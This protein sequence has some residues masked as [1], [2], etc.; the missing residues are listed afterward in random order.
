MNSS[1]LR[2]KFLD[3]FKTNNHAII[4]SASLIPDND[5]SVLF[6]TAGMHPLVPYIMGEKHAEGKRL[7][8]VQKC[9]RTGDIDEVGDKTHHT[10]FEMLGN[11]SL[12]DYWKSEA[13][14]L[15]WNFLINELQLDKNKIAISIF[16]GNS[17]VPDYDSE[18]EKIWLDIG[19]PTE[20]I[21]KVSDN[22]WGPA[23]KTGPC[24]PDTEIFYW[25][26]DG[27]A[28]INFDEK[29]KNWVEIWNN[30]F[31][32]YNKNAQGNFEPLQQRTI[33]TGMGLERTVAAINDLDDNYKTDLFWSTIQN[34]EKI[35]GK[36]YMDHEKEFRVIVD[37]VRSAA[38]ILGDE[39]SVTPSNT[40]AGYVLR[41]LIRRAI[42]FGRKLGIQE[43]FLDKLAQDIVN[44]F[45]DIYPELKQNAQRIYVELNK[46]EDKFILTIEKGLKILH[47]Q[48][49]AHDVLPNKK[50]TA[51]DVSDGYVPYELTGKFLFDIYQSYGFPLELSLEEILKMRRLSK[52]EINQLQQEFSSELERHQ[53]LSRTA[54]AGMFKGG[55]ADDSAMSRKYHTATHLLLQALRMVLGDSVEQ[56]GSHINQERLRFDFVYGQKMTADQISEVENIVNQQIKRDLSVSWKEMTV[57]EAKQYGA[58][59]IFTHKYGEKVKVYTM[60]DFSK[61][62]CGGPHVEHTADLGKFKIIKEESS[63]AGVRRI[64]A[65]LE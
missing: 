41:R 5:P 53:E 61:E 12:G 18:S 25:S 45:E 23:G 28:P 4:G 7:A 2:Q 49:E 64:K 11:W 20:R 6:T 26:G 27:P 22:W 43:P 50:I 33:D 36:S 14:K 1:Q 57:D 63:S 54:S 17:D 46:E 9:V 19:V 3:F 44:N 38:F 10:F 52:I 55:L 51:V 29:D 8:S 34:L 39:K 60:G 30:V 58:I 56:R 48:M 47:T 16:G 65:I 13:I 32:Q 42:R 37:H 59:G 62:I 35:S 40:G 15:S 31:M 24:G 21:T